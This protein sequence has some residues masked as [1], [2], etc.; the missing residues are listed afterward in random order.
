MR[1]MRLYTS[2]PL[3]FR[4]GW[5]FSR[6][7]FP[8]D[9]ISKDSS[10][11]QS[12][13]SPDSF[14][15]APEKCKHT[16][17]PLP[18]ERTGQ[19]SQIPLT[20]L[21]CCGEGCIWHVSNPPLFSWQTERGLLNGPSQLCCLLL[22]QLDPLVT[23]LLGRGGTVWPHYRLA[24]GLCLHRQTAFR[25]SSSTFTPCLPLTPGRSLLLNSSVSK[26]RVLRGQD[27]NRLPEQNNSDSSFNKHGIHDSCSGKASQLTGTFLNWQV[28]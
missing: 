8:L 27:P 12:Y 3:L 19:R 22:S 2:D 24:R 11:G 16:V 17:V 23:H 20:L 18:R 21:G 6:K 28:Y 5:N 26:H 14:T 1:H 25:A 4:T 10:H 9:T 13:T 15:R 7:D